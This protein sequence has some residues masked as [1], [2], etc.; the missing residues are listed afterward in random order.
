MELVSVDLQSPEPLKPDVKLGLMTPC[1]CCC[2][3]CNMPGCPLAMIM[4]GGA[5]LINVVVDTGGGGIVAIVCIN[6]GGCIFAVTKSWYP[7]W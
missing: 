2:C 5:M 4:L 3:C 6:G 7:V 1:C